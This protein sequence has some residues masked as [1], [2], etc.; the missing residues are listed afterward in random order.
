M[1]TRR[2]TPAERE[3]K[4]NGAPCASCRPELLAANSTAIGVYLRCSG[5]CIVSPMGDRIA[6]N[7]LAVKCF[8]DLEGVQIHDQ[9]ETLEKVQFLSDLIFREQAKEAERQREA[10]KG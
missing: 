1:I 2:D 7:F 3:Q 4:K 9:A 8:M 10:A 5:Q 6:L